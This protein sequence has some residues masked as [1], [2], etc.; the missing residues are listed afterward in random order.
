MREV[1]RTSH[2]VFY[3]CF[4]T[5]FFVSLAGFHRTHSC[6]AQ[7]HAV[8]IVLQESSLEQGFFFFVIKY[9]CF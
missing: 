2:G 3:S 7:L 1:G 5:A 8:D 9:Y 4:A 6:P